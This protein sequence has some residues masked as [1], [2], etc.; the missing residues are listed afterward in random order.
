M[1]ARASLLG[2]GRG[3]RHLNSG[4]VCFVCCNTSADLSPLWTSGLVSVTVFPEVPALERPSGT[5]WW[6]GQPS[7][8]M[9]GETEAW[10]LK[11][12][13]HGHVASEGRAGS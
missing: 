1:T 9:Y 7:H 4:I 11:S 2:L 6:P 8:F 3:R 5:A 12:L 10:R 13:D